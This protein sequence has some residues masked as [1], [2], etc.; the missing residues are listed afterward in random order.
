MWLQGRQIYMLSTLCMSY[1][2][3]EIARYSKGKLDA[4]VRKA[5]IDAAYKAAVFNL[6][7]GIRQEDGM[8]YFSLTADGLP[9][10]Y[11]RKI[12]SACFL[13]LGAGVLGALLVSEAESGSADSS[14][15]LPD[16]E[17]LVHES[18]KLLDSIVELT[19]DATKLGR[20]VALPG[21]PAV[22]P[23][24]IPMIL[25]NILD[26]FRFAGVLALRSKYSDLI[27]A[28]YSAIE[29]WCVEEIIK[30]VIVDRKIV[31]ENVDTHGEVILGYDGRHMN[32]GHAI[33]AG[34][35]VLNYAQIND[36]LDLI[37]LAVNMIEWSFEAGWDSKYGGILY[38]LDSEGR[39]PPYLEWNMKLWW[40]HCEAMVA[41]G[42]LYS[43]FKDKG[44]IKRADLY[45]K[46]FE[47]IAKYTLEHFSDSEK[48]CSFSGGPGI[49]EWYGYLDQSG[50]KTHRFKG[51]PYKGFFHVPRC[52]FLLTKLLS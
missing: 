32:P 38:F 45:F 11:Q 49:G 2:A 22:S 48:F 30:H 47:M 8:V 26:E 12:F 6:K 21:A 40:P 19:K 37:D 50:Q 17:G 29:L 18:F 5:M 52:L 46:K 16:A 41:Y 42:M 31:L 36:R 33:E 51:G 23:L 24:N 3:D 43:C 27:D 15:S 1:T 9:H 28:D 14:V 20:G 10:T 34:W 25:L 44:D 39:S 35:F 4:T 7:N 13:C